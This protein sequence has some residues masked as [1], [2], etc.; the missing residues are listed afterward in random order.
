MEGAILNVSN[1]RSHALVGSECPGALAMQDLL[2]QIC[3]VS[4]T[5]QCRIESVNW[6][7]HVIVAYNYASSHDGSS[8]SL[9]DKSRRK[10]QAL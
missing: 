5:C 1:L 3:L 7:S 9:T 2:I 10:P 4:L 6:L 8:E